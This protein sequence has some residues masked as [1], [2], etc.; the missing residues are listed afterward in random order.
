MEHDGEAD[1]DEADDGGRDQECDHAEAEVQVLADDPAR[2]AAEPDHDRQLGEV[3]AHQR[4]VGGL[5]GDVGTG[6]A[7]GDADGGVGEGRGVVDAVADH[8]DLAFLADGV[9]RWRRP[10]P[11]ASGRPMPR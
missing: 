6:S 4:D 2:L 1:A 11:R 8:G 10:C 9:V 5:E 3:V 7:H